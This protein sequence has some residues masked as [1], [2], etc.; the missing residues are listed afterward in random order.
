[1]AYMKMKLTYQKR[2]IGGAKGST[3][4]ITVTCTK[5]SDGSYVWGTTFKGLVVSTLVTLEDLISLSMVNGKVFVMY[6]GITVLDESDGKILWNAEF[7]NSDVSV[8]L[9]AKQEIGISAM[10]VVDG[11]SI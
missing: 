11:N 5:I 6:E 2:V 4:D 1:M 8:G 9:K 3:R 7:D 10:P